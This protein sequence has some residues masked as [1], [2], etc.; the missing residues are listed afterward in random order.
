L[1]KRAIA[2]ACAVEPLAFSV[3][4][5]PQLTFDCDIADGVAPCVASLLFPQPDS[6]SAPLAS[7]LS[8]VLIRLIFKSVL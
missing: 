3:C 2:L 5:P 6:T 4:F 7:T 8:A 1:T